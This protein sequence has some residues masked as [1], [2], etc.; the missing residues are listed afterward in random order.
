MSGSKK[1]IGRTSIN[2]VS[3]TPSGFSR[4]TDE[5]GN[6]KPCSEDTEPWQCT[7]TAHGSTTGLIGTGSHGTRILKPA[8]AIQTGCL[9]QLNRRRGGA[10]CA[11]KIGPISRK[12][13]QPVGP[14]KFAVRVKARSILSKKQRRIKSYSCENQTLF[15]V[16]RG[17]YASG[18]LRAASSAESACQPKP[19][20][21]R[22]VRRNPFEPYL[23]LMLGITPS[24]RRPLAPPV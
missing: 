1:R 22:Q 2:R 14:E 9:A 20:S 11:M 23:Q 16:T 12:T 8:C 3:S 6:S 24:L 21:F 5:V 15:L 10:G 4:G 19:Q 7:G 17:R 13:H 18:L